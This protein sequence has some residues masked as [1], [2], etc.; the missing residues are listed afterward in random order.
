[1]LGDGDTVFCFTDGITETFDESGHE[2]S[3]AALRETLREASGLAPKAL[4][5]AV[6]SRVQE[7]AGAAPQFDDIT[8]L[9][10]RRNRLNSAAG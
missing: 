2:F 3:D 8:C 1:M 10:L 6:I 7:F 9:V 4:G 5:E